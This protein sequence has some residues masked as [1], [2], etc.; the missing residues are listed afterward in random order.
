MKF[1]SLTLIPTKKARLSPEVRQRAGDLPETVYKLVIGVSLPV[2]RAFLRLGGKTYP[3][4]F[5]LDE[6]YD[7]KTHVF[8]LPEKPAGKATFGAALAGVHFP[9]RKK[10]DLAEAAEADETDRIESSSSGWAVKTEET[11][12]LAPGLTLTTY[13]IENKAGAPVIAMLLQADPEKTA[14]YVGTPGDGNVSRKARATIP[15]MIAAAEKNGH[16]VLAAVNADFFDIF[17]DFHPAGLCVKNSEVVANGESKRPF[18]GVKTDGTPVI[19]DLEK[20]PDIIKDLRHAAAG[21]QLIVNDGAP[22]DLA[23]GEPFGYTPH[24]RTA[25]GVTAD[26]QILLLEA[27]GRIP[28]HSN[29]ASL[30]DLADFL[31]SHGAVRAINLDGGGS[32]VVYTKGATGYEL[33]TNPADLYHPTEK[34]IREE[35]NCLLITEKR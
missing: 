16:R 30:K 3:D 33:R 26:G 28:A 25:A 34:L 31:I 8:L 29:G 13:H 1:T 20:D 9:L 11:E 35:Y 32:S 4:V 21:L 2:T 15:D 10:A 18:I 12:A 24:P 23:P 17:G 5:N 14:L 6:P 27:D 7:R 19:T 22:F